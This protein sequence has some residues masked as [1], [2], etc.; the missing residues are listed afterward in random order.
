MT[1]HQIDELLAELDR[2]LAVEPSPLVAA[3]ARLQAADA[4]AR[5]SRLKW[6]IP[7]ALATAAAAVGICVL[8]V[9]SRPAASASSVTVADVV[10]PI[11]R[12]SQATERQSTTVPNE[13][14]TIKP[15]APETPMTQAA[16]MEA[17]VPPDQWNG[18]LRMMARNKSLMRQNLTVVE[19]DLGG[20][21]GLEELP[22]LEPLTIAA[23]EP[24]SP[25]SQEDF[26]S[27]Q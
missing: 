22:A 27:Y 12:P 20:S 8:W 21:G 18:I 1:D 6:R 15:T 11:G 17:L 9:R 24:L 13:A 16:P 5:V 3:R 14:R 25:L 7:M 26:G 19:G 10:P 2:A 23:L 4:P